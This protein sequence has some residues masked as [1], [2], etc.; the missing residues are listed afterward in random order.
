MTRSSQG[1]ASVVDS[2]PAGDSAPAADSDS[3]FSLGFEHNADDEQELF[4]N[5]DDY[6]RAFYEHMC[7]LFEEYSNR[8][9]THAEAAK[10]SLPAKFEAIAKPGP[11]KTSDTPKAKFTLKS[12]L[13]KK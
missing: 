3:E 8:K 5:F 10:K 12:L 9:S 4:Q 2:A 6:D 1:E 11:S 13:C 7:D